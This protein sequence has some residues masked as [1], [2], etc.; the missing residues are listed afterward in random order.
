MSRCDTTRAYASAVQGSGNS[1]QANHHRIAGTASWVP[2]MR[3]RS[4]GENPV[5]WRKSTVL[6]P[7]IT[8]KNH[9]TVLCKKSIR[10]LA[11]SF[12]SILQGVWHFLFCPGAFWESVKA[13]RQLWV[14][15]ILAPH[16][17]RVQCSVK[18]V[19]NRHG[20][21]I[22]LMCRLK[23]STGGNTGSCRYASNG[24]FRCRVW[25]HQIRERFLLNR[26]WPLCL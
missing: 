15:R 24:W 16:A 9:T 25:F 23:S 8:I 10:P 12:Q 2:R 13:E 6:C 14:K 19:Q 3:G 17:E 20:P 22:F 5:C 21:S 7:M 4:S 11:R 26:S 18:A 1:V